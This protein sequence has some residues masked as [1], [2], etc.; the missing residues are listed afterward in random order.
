MTRKNQKLNCSRTLS[1]ECC[2]ARI[3][4]SDEEAEEFGWLEIGVPG[5]GCP[6]E[7][8]C[9]C[10]VRRQCGEHGGVCILEVSLRGATRPRVETQKTKAP[11][12]NSNRI[13]SVSRW[14]FT[15][16]SRQSN[17]TLLPRLFFVKW[18]VS[19][20]RFVLNFVQCRSVTARS[21]LSKSTL[22]FFHFAAIRDDGYAINHCYDWL[23]EEK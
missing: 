23:T 3:K 20:K 8:G 18:F 14:P 21:R 15:A 4:S 16:W 5:G 6:M 1:S 11:S 7:I 17:S 22:F 10:L 9:A 12:S 19:L 13:A 2:G